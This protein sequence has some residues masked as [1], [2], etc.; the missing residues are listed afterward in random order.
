ME[1]LNDVAIH[2]EELL[3][4]A[5]GNLSGQ[6]RVCDCLFRT[7]KRAYDRSL[8]EVDGRMLELRLTS[9]PVIITLE[10]D[11]QRLLHYQ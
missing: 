2:V 1:R 3:I 6:A 8:E 9:G 11:R 5:D 4:I 10:S 7:T